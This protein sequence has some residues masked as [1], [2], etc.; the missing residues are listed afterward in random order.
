MS[1]IKTIILTC[2]LLASGLSIQA[3]DKSH[4]ITGR[5]ANANGKG[6]RGVVCKLKNVSDSLVG[7]SLTGNEGQYS[8]CMQDGAR[9]I[10]F[11]HLSYKKES[12]DI[13]PGIYKYD[14]TL[15]SKSN[16]LKE[17]TVTVAPIRR[18]ND[19]L[20]YNTE[21]FKKKEDE[22]IEDV[23]KR[24]PGIEVSPAGE[25][26]YQG[27]SINKLNIEGLDLMGNKYN[28]ATRNMPADAVSQIQVMENN[29]PIRAQDGTVNN[30]HA[31][32][33]I[34]LKKNYKLRPFGEIEG[35]GGKD[36]WAGSA[37]AIKISPKN[38]WLVTATL[39]NRGINLSSLTKEM[40]NYDRMY[41]NEPLPQPVLSNEY[42]GIPPISPIYYLKNKSYFAGINY[43]HS[44]S[45]YSVFRINILYN[46]ENLHQSD[47]TSNKYFSKDTISLHQNESLLSR[48]DILKAQARY[49]LNTPKIYLEDILTGE[50]S[51]CHHN[52]TYSTEYDNIR[53][54]AKSTP[55]F[56][57]NILNSHLKAGSH[58]YTLSS[59]IRAYR[60]KEYLCFHYEGEEPEKQETKTLSLFSRNRVGTSFTLLANTLS[61]AYILEHKNN[62]LNNNTS[63]TNSTSH[64]WL[65]TLETSYSINFNKGELS[66]NLPVEHISYSILGNSFNRFLIAP[67]LNFDM[68]LSHSL[69]GTLDVG[70][71]QEP[72]TQDVMHKGVTFKN[73]RDYAIGLDSMSVHNTSKANLRLSYLNTSSLLSMNM[74]IGWSS[75]KRDYLPEYLYTNSFTLIQP[76]WKDN[77]S[78]T[79]SIAFNAK[80]TFRK[81]G[82]AV[83][84][85]AQYADNSMTVSQNG[86]EGNIRYHAFSTTFKTEWNKLEYL[87]ITCNAGSNMH[88]KQRDCFSDEHNFLKDYEYSFKIDIFPFS[89]TQVYADFSQIFHEITH[90]SYAKTIF[91]NTGVKYKLWKSSTIKFSIVN[92]LNTKSYKESSYN[93]VNY[94]YY[95][96]PL[97][98][99]E[100]LL[101]M[102]LK[103]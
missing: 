25:I 20:I 59:V 26:T 12:R 81:A 71:N 41:T 15:H 53:Q 43:L 16:Q 84:C 21:A 93:G 37:T 62:E 95:E 17:V 23:L 68:K 55:A 33:N 103:I 90:R 44:F 58:I 47:S 13:A 2:I 18:D 27:K 5:V 77:T 61:L 65:H 11:S 97:R 70:Y 30:N 1:N 73:Y 3:Q 102:N 32:L 67:S 4:T 69:T 99:R 63:G 28:Q 72:N 88:W 57:Q 52:G 60:A 82:F 75:R 64:Y 42:F 6:I 45:R 46:H 14:I 83:K 66:V 38:Q 19:T 89:N 10:E 87:H 39:D 101:S 98:G 40:A 86:L 36:L 22:Y 94:S 7:Y 51:W 78:T 35:G 80:K 91:I 92:L 54:S 50:G 24:L 96:M 31:T 9:R 8:I 56:I 29:Q 76:K 100:L 74:L 49:E 34:K 48:S 79:L 85:S